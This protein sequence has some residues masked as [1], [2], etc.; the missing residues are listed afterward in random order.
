MTEKQIRTVDKLEL[1]TNHKAAL[2]IMKNLKG[3]GI[4]PTHLGKLVGLKQPTAS[5]W[6]NATLK[7]LLKRKLVKKRADKT[8]VLCD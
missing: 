8:W 6:A 3:E 7:G 2:E 1:T 4:L 5:S